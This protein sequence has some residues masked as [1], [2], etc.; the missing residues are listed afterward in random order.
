MQKDI[1]SGRYNTKC[2]VAYSQS[3]REDVR[4][5]AKKIR[6][7]SMCRSLRVIENLNNRTIFQK[8]R[9]DKDREKTGT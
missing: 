8:V 9:N 5:Q 4:D 7:I 2:M 6:L 3:S 1:L